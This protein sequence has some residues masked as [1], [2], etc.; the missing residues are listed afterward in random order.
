MDDNSGFITKKKT[1]HYI[2]IYTLCGL[3]TVT[4]WLEWLVDD[5]RNGFYSINQKVVETEEELEKQNEYG[6]ETGLK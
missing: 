4:V 5:Q 1:E 6:F 2:I 3:N